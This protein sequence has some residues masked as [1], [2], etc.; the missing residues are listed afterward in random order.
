[1]ENAIFNLEISYK[2][3]DLQYFSQ[4]IVMRSRVCR[5]ILVRAALESSDPGT[6]NDVSNIAIWHFEADLVSFELS[7]SP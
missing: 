3:I 1:M 4:T 7:E 2:F 6:F 5:T